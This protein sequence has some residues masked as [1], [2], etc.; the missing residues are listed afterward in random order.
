MMRLRGR[1]S[2]FGGPNDEGVAPDEGLAFISDIDD[3]PH[4]FLAYQPSGTTG[5][6][7][8]LDPDK[9]YIACRWAYDLYPKPSLLENVALVKAPK[10]GRVLFAY[11]ADWGPN[12]NTGRVA[13]ISPGLMSALG[14]STDDEVIVTYPFQG[15]EDDMSIHRVAISAGHG[16]HI[17]GC[18][19]NGLHEEI[20]TPKVMREVATQ[21]RQRGVTTMEFADTVSDDQSENLDRIIDWHNMQ[22]RDLDVS[23]HF[24]SSTST[25][26]PIGTEVLY[27]TQEALARKV[28]SAIAAATGLIDRG[29]KFRDGLAF[30]NGTDEPAIMVECLFLD[31]SA[32]VAIYQQVAKF[33]AMCAAIA[34]AIAGT[35]PL[36]PPWPE[37]P[38]RPERPPPVAGTPIVSVSIE[39]PDGVDLKLI[40]NGDVVV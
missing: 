6:A 18:S 24:N 34:T 13:D 35:V 36:R 25:S 22:T 23:I 4:L 1:V 27:L 31:S 7:R 38:E 33:D 40:V 3:A 39:V 17:P 19:G 20:E 15:D 29:P 30:L 37:R 12:E 2:W 28:A 10:T 21:L 9:N 14:I 26:Q 11:P 5:L 32:D 8:R 16:S